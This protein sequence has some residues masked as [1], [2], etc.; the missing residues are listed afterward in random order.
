MP[1]DISKEKLLSIRDAMELFP[2][3]PNRGTIHRWMG[4]GYAGHRLDSVKVGQ[5][6]FTSVEAVS[7]F[8]KKITVQGCEKPPSKVLE[9][10]AC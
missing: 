2:N 8:L 4:D 3:K 10:A 9:G 5:R 1:I 6:R 7:R